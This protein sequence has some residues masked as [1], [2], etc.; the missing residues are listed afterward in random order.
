MPNRH[1]I[2]G[3]PAARRG[4]NLVEFAMVLPLL[5]TMFLGIFDFGWILHQQIA[6]D[7][8][9]REGARRGAVGASD[10]AILDRVQ[11]MVSFGV[12]PDQIT[13]S[14]VDENGAARPQGSRTPG[15][16]II[17]EIE[18][19]DVQ[20]ITPIRNL[21]ATIGTIDLVSEARFRIE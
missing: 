19:P 1:R 18:Q 5:L 20:L 4:N 16:V 7:N 17:V 8:A 10:T 21:V 11:E 2:P 3:M 12:D 14:V 15:D 13:I 9:T 6:L